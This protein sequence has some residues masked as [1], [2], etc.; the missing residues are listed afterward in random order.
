MVLILA[1]VTVMTVENFEQLHDLFY[2]RRPFR[3]FTITLVNGDRFEVDHHRA[4]AFRDG[5]GMFASPG[6]IPILF[7]HESVS[8]IIGDLMNQPSE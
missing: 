7:D 6:G 4:L 3:P 1:T 5:Y 8:Q 2:L